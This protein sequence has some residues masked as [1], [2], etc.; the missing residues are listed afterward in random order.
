VSG[1]VRLGAIIGSDGKIR[2]LKFASI[3]DADLGIAA[4]AAVR[5]WRYQPYL[6]NGV[7]VDVQTEIT[8][9]FEI[10]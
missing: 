3:P 6:L 9:N 5:H 4:V 8:V 10:R 2:S 1:T 7:P